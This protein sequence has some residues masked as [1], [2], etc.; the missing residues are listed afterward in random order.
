M[1]HS[2][3]HVLRRARSEILAAFVDGSIRQSLTLV[4]L[5]LL[6]F[7]KGIN[8]YSLLRITTGEQ[9][10]KVVFVTKLKKKHFRRSVLIVRSLYKI[11]LDNFYQFTL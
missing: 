1:C 6:A 7:A 9:D 4:G 8:K 2:Y 11:K 10:K 5:S 3:A